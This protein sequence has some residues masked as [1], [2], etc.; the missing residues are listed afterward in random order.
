MVLPDSLVLSRRNLHSRYPV[1]GGLLA[2]AAGD[3]FGEE[4][5]AIAALEVPGPSVTMGFPVGIECGAP[6][7]VSAGR[8]R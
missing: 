7:R 2:A 3:R 8:C 4:G 1:L 6:R 5:S